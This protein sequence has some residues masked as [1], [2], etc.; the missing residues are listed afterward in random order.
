MTFS[1]VNIFGVYVAPISVMMLVAWLATLLL[2]WLLMLTGLM[3]HVWH[4]SLFAFALFLVVL[5]LMVLS[6]PLLRGA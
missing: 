2:R 6:A 3:R 5:S 1:E 4:P